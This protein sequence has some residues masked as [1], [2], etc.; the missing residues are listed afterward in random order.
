MTAPRPQHPAKRCMAIVPACGRED[1]HQCPYAG[2]VIVDRA[3]QRV[4]MCSRHAKSKR[5][6]D[7]VE[8]KPVP[9]NMHHHERCECGHCRCEHAAGFERCLCCGCMRYTWPGKGADL[10]A[11]HHR[12]ATQ[13]EGTK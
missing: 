6:V 1:A 5:A 2:A 12:A 9:T 11:D 4:R 13:P 8:D 10:P 7:V 3:G